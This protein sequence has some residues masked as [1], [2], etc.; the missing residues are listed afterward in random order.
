MFQEILLI[1]LRINY[2][3]RADPHQSLATPTKALQMTVK[4]EGKNHSLA[5]YLQTY[6]KL[7][8]TM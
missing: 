1:P 7:Q 5:A 8:D 4:L 6:W 3:L 2:L